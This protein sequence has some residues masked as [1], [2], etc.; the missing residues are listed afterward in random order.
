M[1]TTE[2]DLEKFES[3]LERELVRQCE[4]SGINVACRGA[5]PGNECMLLASPDIDGLWDKLGGEYVADAMP[6]LKDYPSVAFAW[7]GYLG[8]AVACGWDTDW[9][10]CSNLP[11]SSYYG[12]QGFDDM[13]DHIM[14]DILGIALDSQEAMAVRNLFRRCSDAVISMIRHENVEAQSITAY[15]V[16]VLSCRTMYR[17]GAA[18]ELKR[19]GYKLEKLS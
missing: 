19:L 12:K 16:F 3:R 7:A 6:Q 18:V 11:Y 13:D 5:E 17:I 1:N 8:M 4:A 10:F 15:H 2:Y 14:Q 9:Q